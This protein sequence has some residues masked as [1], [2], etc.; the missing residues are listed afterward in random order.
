MCSLCSLCTSI[1]ASR[2]FTGYELE[3]SDDSNGAIRNFSNR[4]LSSK[5]QRQ[6]LESSLISKAFTVVTET[7]ALT[8]DGHGVVEYD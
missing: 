6:Y 4:F 1:K 5:P 2:H 3:M 7:K 8:D